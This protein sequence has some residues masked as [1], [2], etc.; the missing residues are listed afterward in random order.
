MNDLVVVHDLFMD[1]KFTQAMLRTGRVR[2]HGR[3]AEVL[4]LEPEEYLKAVENAGVLQ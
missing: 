1:F 2:A 3:A 4:Q